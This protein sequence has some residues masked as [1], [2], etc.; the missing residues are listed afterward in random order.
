MICIIFIK[1]D[2]FVNE[3]Y[4]KFIGIFN[5]VNDMYI[6]LFFNILIKFLCEILYL[7]FK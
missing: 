7:K 3:L 2:F 4:R 1:V 5:N 6:V